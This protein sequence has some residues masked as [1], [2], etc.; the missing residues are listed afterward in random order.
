MIFTFFSTVYHGAAKKAI[1]LSCFPPVR[2]LA[3]FW[4]FPALF[5]EKSGNFRLLPSMD[6]GK[7]G[8]SGRKPRP[9]SF[10]SLPGDSPPASSAS[11]DTISA[12]E[13]LRRTFRRA[14]I[15]AGEEEDDDDVQR[16]LFAAGKRVCPCP[17]RVKYHRCAGSAGV[18]PFLFRKTLDFCGRTGLSMTKERENTK[19]SS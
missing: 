2:F 18:F 17:S 12:P 9:A 16:R 15:G 13:K 14:K 19:G 1:L 4:H 3:V 5:P 6:K 7:Y 10:S 8:F 11:P